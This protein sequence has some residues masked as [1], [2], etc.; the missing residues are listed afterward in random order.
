MEENK[1]E[2]EEAKKIDNFFISNYASFMYIYI[3]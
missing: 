3:I 2:E 1:V